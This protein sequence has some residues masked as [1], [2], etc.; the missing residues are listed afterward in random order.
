MICD[1]GLDRFFY[2][3]WLIVGLLMMLIAAAA[4][5]LVVKSWKKWKLR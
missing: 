1:P 2:R 3:L 5:Y 4:A